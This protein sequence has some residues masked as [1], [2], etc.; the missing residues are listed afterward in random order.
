M[1][2]KEEIFQFLEALSLNNSKEWMDQN[3]AQYQKTKQSWLDEIQRILDRLAP[4][5]PA[6]SHVE[7]KKTI[8]R[9]NN[10]RRF[11]PDKPIY[12]D[13]YSCS[14]TGGPGTPAFH[15]SISPSESFIAGGLYKPEKEQLLKVRQA[16]DYDGE[17][18]KN[19]LNAPAFQ[20]HFGGLSDTLDQKLKRV[21]RGFPKDHPHTDLLLYKS[22]T[23]T[24]QLTTAEVCSEQ[25]IDLVEQAY[26]ALQPMNQYLDQALNFED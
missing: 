18:F 15:I 11:Q 16:F 14:V 5:D 19:I 7:P 3:R 24:R 9:I 26:L 10:N 25:F 21:P 22:I 12:K 6:L 20:K 13:F 8:T 1:N 4:Y 17:E 2:R 23:A